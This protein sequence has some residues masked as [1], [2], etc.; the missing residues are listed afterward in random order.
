MA[1]GSEISDVLWAA[2]IV[3]L[4][5]ALSQYSRADEV[6]ALT[7]GVACEFGVALGSLPRERNEPIAIPHY[8]NN[9]Q[10]V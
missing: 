7:I 6:A 3:G 4:R 9:V 1:T 8:T 10:T 2:V 5:P